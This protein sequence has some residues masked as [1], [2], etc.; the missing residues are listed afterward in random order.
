MKERE[1]PAINLTLFENDW[2]VTM[3]KHVNFT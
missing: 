3:T 1:R 2:S